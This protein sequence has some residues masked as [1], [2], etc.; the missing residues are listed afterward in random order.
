MKAPG[1]L[2]RFFEACPGP[3]L[4]EV[5]EAG[6]RDQLKELGSGIPTNEA[7]RYSEKDVSDLHE[8][9]QTLLRLRGTIPISPML[10]RETREYL[11]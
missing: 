2:R 8:I 6:V 1:L 7:Y 11:P 10:G 3:K 9:Y 5:L 4:V